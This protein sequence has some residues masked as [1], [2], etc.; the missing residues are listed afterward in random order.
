VTLNDERYVS[1]VMHYGGY[2]GGAH[3]YQ[4]VA[5]FTYDKREQRELKI[6]DLY[7]TPEQLKEAVEEVRQK[8][9]IQMGEAPEFS[10]GDIDGSWLAEGTDPAKPE[11]FA[12]FTLAS[13]PEIQGDHIT[14]YFQQYQ[15]A[16]YAF[17]MPTVSMLYG[18]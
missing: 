4:I 3:G 16:A 5:T 6:T 12:A 7:T 10:E 18:M 13:V 8:L 14:F 17:G 15:V 2:V 1:L 11:N 9:R